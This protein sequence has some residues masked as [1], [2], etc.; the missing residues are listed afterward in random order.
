[1]TLDEKIIACA[2]SHGYKGNTTSAVRKTN[3][4]RIYYVTGEKDNPNGIYAWYVT[5]EQLKQWQ[6]NEK[7]KKLDI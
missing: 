4:W 7:L 5:D 2:R 1:M 6:R 3:E